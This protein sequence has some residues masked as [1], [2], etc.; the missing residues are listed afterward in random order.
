MAK[1][2]ELLAPAGNLEKLKT[3]I[4]FGADAVYLG[5]KTFGLRAFGGNFTQEAMEEGV[6]FA[7]AHGKKVYVTLN[8]FPH[9]QDVKAFPA[10]LDFL[11]SIDA[12]AVLVSDLGLFMQI[13]R[14][15]PKMELHISTQANNV[16]QLTVNAWHELGASRIVLA[17]E[18]SRIEI[19]SIRESTQAELEMFVHGAMCISYSG[20]CLLS[21]YFTGRDANRGACAQVCRWK[22]ALVEETR[23]NEYFPVAEDE[24]GTYIMNSKD[25]CLLP[26]V[27]ELSHMGM[28]SLK[29][30]GRMKSVHYVA[31][32]VKVY[33]EAIDAYAVEGSAF[34][35][36]HAWEEELLKAS[37]RIY[38]TGFYERKP[39]GN[40]Q[41]YDT[42]A[43][44]QTTDFV[45]VVSDYDA[46]TGYAEVEQRNLMECGD[47]M[48]VLQPHGAP[49]AVTIQDM[50][51]MDGISIKRAPHA[52][53]HIRIRFGRPVEAN[54]LLRRYRKGCF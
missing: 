42:S 15:S 1:K 54:A 41:I 20:R 43:Y 27:G 33:R 47:T 18:L 35:V 40:A 29:I 9:E 4:R 51:D 8:I 13:K 25:L 39:V 48:E 38:T 21:S 5:G 3:A 49:Y 32:V 30:E 2:P 37:H 7:H 34:T 12:D 26:Y 22:F 36:R 11:Q 31:T 45:G 46:S 24:R 50:T 19:E 44:E 28:D 6:R 10:Y 53:Q 23:P 16:N 17:R 14:E 52:Q